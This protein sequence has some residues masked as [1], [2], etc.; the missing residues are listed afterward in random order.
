MFLGTVFKQLVMAN[1]RLR[2]AEASLL[3]T[4]IA[5]SL[6]HLYTGKLP[7]V[8]TRTHRVEEHGV[9]DPGA[10]LGRVGPQQAPRARRDVVRVEPA[11]LDLRAAVRRLDAAGRDTRHSGLIITGRDCRFAGCCFWYEAHQTEH[12]SSQKLPRKTITLSQVR[13]E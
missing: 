8:T 2:T 1:T 5:P 9:S 6:G 10:Q 7:R 3:L 11:E 4:V 13:S 12:S